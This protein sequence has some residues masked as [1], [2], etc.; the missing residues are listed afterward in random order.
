M[1]RFMLY[2]ACV[3]AVALAVWL[4]AGTR[5]SS[6][7][8]SGATQTSDAGGANARTPA[9]ATGANAAEP[10]HAA[11]EARARNPQTAGASSGL[12]QA[13]RD[14]SGS[15]RGARPDA[16]QDGGELDA[17]PGALAPAPSNAP[18]VLRSLGEGEPPPP[19]T[20]RDPRDGAAAPPMGFA[21]QPAAT[22]P[23]PQDLVPAA[24]PPGRP[25]PTPTPAPPEQTAANPGNT[26]TPEILGDIGA[27]LKA[28]PL[29]QLPPALPGANNPGP[30]SNA[31][32]P[33]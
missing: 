15:S 24:S 19:E 27:A 9:S 14:G 17:G 11:A 10:A 18:R 2:A 1:R 5:E 28:N 12:E 13:A 29:D 7:P 20:T 4:V 22:G 32:S 3:A 23:T 26:T 25:A 16:P 33:P 6:E 21:P 30:P 31:G 8:P